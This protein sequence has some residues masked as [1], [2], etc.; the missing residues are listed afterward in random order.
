MQGQIASLEPE[1]PSRGAVQF[2]SHGAARAPVSTPPLDRLPFEVQDRF[3]GSAQETSLLSASTSG[4][5]AETAEEGLRNA[6]LLRR[7]TENAALI[8][9]EQYHHWVRSAE[10]VFHYIS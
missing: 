6:P 2:S 4:A 9:R 1:P 8:V 10:T 5:L 3:R 7:I